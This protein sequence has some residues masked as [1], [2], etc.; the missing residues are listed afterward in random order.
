MHVDL[1]KGTTIA[2]FP[3]IINPESKLNPNKSKALKLYDSQVRKLGKNPKDK[4]DVI[5]SEHKLQTMGFVDFFDHLSTTQQEK[6]NKS[7][8]QHFIPWRAVWNTNSLSTP[9]RLVSDASL[10]T[11]SGYSLNGLLAKGC[12]NMNKLVE[13]LI[14]GLVLPTLPLG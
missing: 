12:N 14:R 6:I 11:S 8:I 3:F 4:D 13:I 5:A 1:Q 9:C 7:N 2:K 10:T